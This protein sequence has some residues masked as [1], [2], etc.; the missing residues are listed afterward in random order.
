M[1]EP[2]AR[3]FETR[4]GVFVVLGGYLRDISVMFKNYYCFDRLIF[5]SL[6]CRVQGTAA[7]NQNVSYLWHETRGKVHQW[8]M[9]QGR[10]RLDMLDFVVKYENLAEF[11]VSE[12][13]DRSKA[14]ASKIKW[15]QTPQ[16]NA[17]TPIKMGNFL[18]LLLRR[19]Q[20]IIFSYR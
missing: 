9:I 20:R 15:G 19:F 7:K 8:F 12:N 1:N 3:I 16:R 6:K 14:A 18:L 11:R 5:Q 10:P 2:K 4:A 17:N 13:T